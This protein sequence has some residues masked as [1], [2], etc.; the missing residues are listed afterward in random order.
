M[1]PIQSQSHMPQWNRE[2]LTRLSS[3]ES[4]LPQWLEDDLGVL[5]RET[6]VASVENAD[7]SP[8]VI[9]AILI[10]VCVTGLLA[11]AFPAVTD[12]TTQQS[13]SIAGFG[14]LTTVLVILSQLIGH[15]YGQTTI[16]EEIELQPAQGPTP[17]GP[18]IHRFEVMEHDNGGDLD[19]FGFDLPG[20]MTS[21]QF[22]LLLRS[23]VAGGRNWSRSTAMGHGISQ[24]QFRAVSHAM[25]EGQLL[26][27]ANGNNRQLTER[28]DSWARSVLVAYGQI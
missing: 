5:A 16:T 17:T 1:R 12:T 6:P 20:G 23:V 27:Q 25:L 13:M 19:E 26:M 21:L 4:S 3:V 8:A 7:I 15:V 2:M 9:A 24:G 28:G 22:V 18:V 14:G 11:M 10:G